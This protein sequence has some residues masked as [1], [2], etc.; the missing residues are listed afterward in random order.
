VQ[1]FINK[2]LICP[3]PATGKRPRSPEYFPLGEYS[4]AKVCEHSP[5]LLWF[6]R[7]IKI[8]AP[9]SVPDNC[10][11]IIPLY[12]QRNLKFPAHPFIPNLVLKHFDAG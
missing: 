12:I 2:K 9:F 6:N 4:P 3:I 11:Q 7:E 5:R 1:I 10:N 8:N